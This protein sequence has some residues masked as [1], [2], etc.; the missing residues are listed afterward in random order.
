MVMNGEGGLAHTLS[1]NM[2]GLTREYMRH[3]SYIAKHR[4]ERPKR[5]LMTLLCR[6]FSVHGLNIVS[7]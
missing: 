7:N 2:S 1:R 5:V 6:I 3:I 4:S